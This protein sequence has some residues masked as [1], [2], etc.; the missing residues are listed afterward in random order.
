MTRTEEMLERLRLERLQLAGGGAIPERALRVVSVRPQGGSSSGGGGRPAAAASCSSSSSSSSAGA[1]GATQSVAGAEAD[2]AAR[3]EDRRLLARALAQKPKEEVPVLE[4]KVSSF[5]YRYIS[6]ESCSQFDSLPLT[7]L[8]IFLT[9]PV[10]ETK[11]M[12]ELRRLR[13]APVSVSV[14]RFF[15]A[16]RIQCTPAPLRFDRRRSRLCVFSALPLRP[17]CVPSALPL[18]CRYVAAAFPLRRLCAATA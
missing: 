2:R 6:R 13:Q 5:M 18:R 17:L 7:S 12:R 16:Q 3:A 15:V 11:A 10:L 4:T 9:R 1:G 8:T 14:V